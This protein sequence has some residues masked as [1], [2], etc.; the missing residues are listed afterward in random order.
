MPASHEAT[1]SS[2]ERAR[3]R[4]GSSEA[5]SAGSCVGNLGV[6]SAWLPLVN[7]SANRPFASRVEIQSLTI[8]KPAWS[9]SGGFSIWSP[10]VSPDPASGQCR[11][12]GGLRPR[13][14]AIPPRA[15]LTRSATPDEE[16]AE[17]EPPAA[18]ETRCCKKCNTVKPIGLFRTDRGIGLTPKLLCAPPRAAR[19]Q[20][21]IAPAKSPA[22][23]LGTRNQQRKPPQHTP[24]SAKR[25]ARASS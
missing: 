3:V 10:D 14:Q 7:R 4:A 8:P 23:G 2:S 19:S 9:A 15:R 6:M 25:C 21:G 11:G 5:G 17:P 18:E 1:S 16:A 12:I 24:P 22:G 20:S 13:R